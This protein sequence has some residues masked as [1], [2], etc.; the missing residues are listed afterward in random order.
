MAVTRIEGR[1]KEEKADRNGLIIDTMRK[2]VKAD[3]RS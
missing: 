3:G 2:G 1:I